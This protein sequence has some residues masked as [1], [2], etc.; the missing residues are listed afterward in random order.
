MRYC[1]YEFGHAFGITAPSALNVGPQ[2]LSCV[3]GLI[4][5]ILLRYEER[6]FLLCQWQSGVSLGAT[7]ALVAHSRCPV[8]RAPLSGAHI[9]YPR[10]V[11]RWFPQ[12]GGEGRVR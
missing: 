11:V 10:S 8:W 1:Q 12:V 5:G 6:T 2:S 9:P 4:R 3:P 7:A